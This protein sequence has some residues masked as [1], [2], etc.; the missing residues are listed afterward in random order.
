MFV[1]DDVWILDDCVL[2]VVCGECVD[3][4]FVCVFEIE[5]GIC[6]LCGD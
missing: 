2:C 6:L 3:C 1:C 5:V 4:F